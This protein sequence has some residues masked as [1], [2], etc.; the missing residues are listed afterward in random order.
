VPASGRGTI[1]SMTTVHRQ[2]SPDLPVPYTNALVQ[3]EEGPRLLTTI[4]GAPAR[5]GD[6]VRV[7]WKDRAGAPPLPVFERAESPTSREPR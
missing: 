6:P 7:T 2:V 5:I 1:Y 3:L 4:V